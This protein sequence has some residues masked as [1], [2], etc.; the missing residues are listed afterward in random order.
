MGVSYKITDEVLRFIMAQK[1]ANPKI[2]CQDISDEIFKQFQVKVSKSSVHDALKQQGIITPRQRKV[3]DNF[4]LPE[5]AK[6]KIKEDIIKLGSGLIDAPVAVEKVI[7]EKIETPLPPPT[8]P[9]SPEPVQEIVVEPLAV[10]EVPLE[11]PKEEPVAIVKGPVVSDAGKVF[12]DAASWE[13]GLKPGQAFPLN[14]RAYISFLVYAYKLEFNDRDP[15]FIDAQF[16]GIGLQLSDFTPNPRLLPRATLEACDRLVT[17]HKPLIIDDLGNTDLSSALIRALKDPKALIKIGLCDSQGQSITEWDNFLP[18]AHVLEIKTDKNVVDMTRLDFTQID[19]SDLLIMTYTLFQPGMTLEE[20]S[21]VIR[22]EG[23]TSKTP[24][25]QQLTLIVPDG[26]ASK[27]Q[28]EQICSQING[29]SIH[30]LDQI[31]LCVNT[32][33]TANF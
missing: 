31:P 18:L 4:E 6:L 29:L 11:L 15:I 8:L 27:A 26:F 5:G 19:T 32:S 25:Q 21:Q 7:V 22:F 13:M 2:S 24:T 12:L 1:T 30:V 20:F 33:S 16:K 28:V 14:D 9:V 23:F 3:K 17:N 10:V